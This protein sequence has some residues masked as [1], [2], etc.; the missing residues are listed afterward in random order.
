M[1]IRKATSSGAFSLVLFQ[2]EIANDIIYR[3]VG[4]RLRLQRCSQ[5]NGGM[6]SLPFKH[7][8]ET[9]HGSF[10]EQRRAH[11]LETVTAPMTDDDERATEE[12]TYG[13]TATVLRQYAR[14]SA[15]CVVDGASSSEKGVTA[16]ESASNERVR[17]VQRRALQSAA[18]QRA[19][20]DY[21]RFNLRSA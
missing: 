13:V 1:W 2:Q 7:V 9:S 16:V 21:G 8:E 17:T 12:A 20:F 11:W 6:R 4:S 18:R 3:Q 10:Q 5:W 14:N 19:L 15:H